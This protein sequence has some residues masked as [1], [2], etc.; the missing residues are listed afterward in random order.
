MGV[1]VFMVVSRSFVALR[2]VGPSNLIRTN[3]F[4][5]EESCLHLHVRWWS[6]HNP[7]ILQRLSAKINAIK[8]QN[9]KS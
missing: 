8:L 7:P 9:I 4:F 1:E 5:P 3:K 2:D 6:K